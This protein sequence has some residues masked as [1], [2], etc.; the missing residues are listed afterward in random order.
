MADIYQI[1][2]N[3]GT[4][5]SIEDR[6][7]RT[8]TAPFFS[9]TTSYSKGDIVIKDGDLYEFNVTH[10]AGSWVDNQATTTNL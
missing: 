10:S 7:S 2:E 3:N 6:K 4:P 5:K 9:T 8:N 1:I